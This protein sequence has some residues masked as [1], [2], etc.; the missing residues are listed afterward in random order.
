MIEKDV[1]KRILEAIKNNGGKANTVEISELTGL[2]IKSVNKGAK[3]LISRALISKK[4]PKKVYPKLPNIYHL[5]Q[6]LINKIDLLISQ[7]GQDVK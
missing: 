1:Q 3:H 6:K 5:N 7:I 2:S 4:K